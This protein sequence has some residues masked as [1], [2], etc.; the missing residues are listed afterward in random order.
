[1]EIKHLRFSV[2]D[3]MRELSSGWRASG[4]LPLLQFL[5]E[6]QYRA[7]AVTAFLAT[8][9]L[10]RLGVV[11]V[12]QPRPSPRSMSPEPRLPFSVD[13]VRDTYR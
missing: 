8:L 1:M 10:I 13:E 12:F 9:E 7:E 2:A 3:K 5:G 6:M 11:T 4:A